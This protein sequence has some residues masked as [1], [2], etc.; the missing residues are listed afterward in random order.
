M[1]P[2]YDVPIQPLISIVN[3]TI[4]QTF[5]CQSHHSLDLPWSYTCPC[6][7]GHCQSPPLIRF[8]IA[9]HQPCIVRCGHSPIIYTQSP[10][11]PQV[12]T[13]QFRGFCQQG[14]VLDCSSVSCFY[15]ELVSYLCLCVATCIKVS[16]NIHV[17]CMHV[18]YKVYSAKS[19]D[20]TT[21]A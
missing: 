8:K 5:D 17:A 18:H 19:N 16:M 6:I 2:T 13:S 12:S 14:L 3:H 9:L 15:V 1:P 21:S 11:W 10:M 7:Y 20:F 4:H